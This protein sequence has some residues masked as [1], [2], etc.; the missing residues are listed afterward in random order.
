MRA[1]TWSRFAPDSE[2]GIRKTF[3]LLLAIAGPK[4]MG[5]SKLPDQFMTLEYE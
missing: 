1:D 4:V 3:D 2:S 5:V